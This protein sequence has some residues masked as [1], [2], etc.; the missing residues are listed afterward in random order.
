MY[1]W[2]CVTLSLMGIMIAFG[3]VGSEVYS[4]GEVLLYGLVGISALGAG[5]IL[6]E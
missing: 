3:A 1:N 6:H 5:I 4:N 2:L